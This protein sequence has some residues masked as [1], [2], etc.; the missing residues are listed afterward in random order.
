MSHDPLSWY[1]ANRA[2]LIGFLRLIAPQDVAEDAVQE[3]YIVLQRT[4]ERFVAGADPGAWVR[5]IARNLARQALTRRGRQQAMP[6]EALIERFD[7]AA[8]L[9]DADA[10]DQ[11]DDERE[12]LARCLGALS[13]A[14]R[15]L[16]RLRYQDDLSLKQLAERSRRSAGAIQVALSRLRATLSACIDQA[17]RRR[18]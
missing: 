12:Q 4:A 18:R 15:E 13:P 3:T 7:Q 5:G 17:L 8:A 11:R 2:L 10:L 16:I 9:A 14:N 6:P 1:L